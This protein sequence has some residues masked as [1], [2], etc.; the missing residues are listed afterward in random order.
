[1][2]LLFLYDLLH[3]RG[4]RGCVLRTSEARPCGTPDGL[5]NL[6]GVSACSPRHTRHSSHVLILRGRDTLR[7]D[8]F[9]LEA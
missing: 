9:L 5:F 2:L 3:G 8:Y 6:T 1:M 4:Q 7:C